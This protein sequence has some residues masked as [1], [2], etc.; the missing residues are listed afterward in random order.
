MVDALLLQTNVDLSKI[1]QITCTDVMIIVAENPSHSVQRLIMLV[2]L[3]NHID[4]KME[5]VLKMKVIVELKT[6]VLSTLQSNV[7]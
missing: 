5:L 3:F 6:V 2:Q 4:V 7:L 1:V